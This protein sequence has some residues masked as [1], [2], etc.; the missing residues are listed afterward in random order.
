MMAIAYAVLEGW[1][2]REAAL[3]W[4]VEFW[5]AADPKTITNDYRDLLANNGYALCDLCPIEM[6]DSI[7]WAYNQ[8]IMQSD[9]LRSLEDCEDCIP[10]GQ[11]ECLAIPRGRY[12]R[13]S[14]DDLHKAMEWW[15]C[16]QP[17]ASLS[18][19]SDS[20]PQLPKTCNTGFSPALI[21]PKKKNEKEFWKL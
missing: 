19:P 3:T 18:L 4:L 14:L 21:L 15:A 8:Q 5:Q 7:R 11:E 10:M 20:P 1:I 13:N 17:E 9:F 12:E 2:S 16:Y 6:M